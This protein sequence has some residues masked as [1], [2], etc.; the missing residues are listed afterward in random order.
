M[1]KSKKAE[2]QR[3]WKVMQVK[4]MMVTIIS[5]TY[6]DFLNHLFSCFCRSRQSNTKKDY[7]DDDTSDHRL[8]GRCSHSPW[9]FSLLCSVKRRSLKEKESEGERNSLQITWEKQV[10]VSETRT[11]RESDFFFL[12]LTL[13]SWSKVQGKTF[14]RHEIVRE[15]G[16]ERENRTWTWNTSI[17]RS[18]VTGME[19]ASQA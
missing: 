3:V 18:E 13:I 12:L 6:P 14:E 19:E 5:S 9:R 7:H 17:T 11:S 2:L 10:C 15:G 16:E 8:L 4:F 1:Q